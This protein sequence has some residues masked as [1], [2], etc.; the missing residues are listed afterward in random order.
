LSQM[1]TGVVA[2][3]NVI[4]GPS[5]SSPGGQRDEAPTVSSPGKAG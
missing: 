2:M 3:R 5:Q 1:G 4:R